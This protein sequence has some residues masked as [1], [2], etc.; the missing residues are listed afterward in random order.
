MNGLGLRILRNAAE[1]EDVVQEVFVQVWRQAE[2]YDPDRGSAEAWLC[3]IARSRALDRLR[4]RASRREEPGDALP[5]SAS[6]RPRPEEVL[7]VR[8]A[9]E[10]LSPTSAR[11]WSSPTTKASPRPRSRTAWDSPWARSRPASARR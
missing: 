10:A 5:A 7:A 1:A 2:R 3:T 6:E 9:L 11:P 4:R 8:K